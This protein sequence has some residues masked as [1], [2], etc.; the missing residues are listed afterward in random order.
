MQNNPI[1]SDF[2]QQIHVSVSSWDLFGVD[3]YNVGKL[4]VPLV[5]R[6]T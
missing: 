4:I 5:E 2:L 6:I 3:N 1:K